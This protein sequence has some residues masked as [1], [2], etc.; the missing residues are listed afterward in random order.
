MTAGDLWER[1]WNVP[2]LPP[3]KQ[4]QSLANGI[5]WEMGVAKE[6]IGRADGQGGVAKS[7][8]WGR[9]VGGVE[10]VRREVSQVSDPVGV[11]PPPSTLWASTPYRTFPVCVNKDENDNQLSIPSPD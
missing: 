9:Q 1:R 7:W 5:V 3:R 6:M 4:S 8:T 2:F 10:V 11:G